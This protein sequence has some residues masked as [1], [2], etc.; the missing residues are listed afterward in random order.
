MDI[1]VADRLR[2]G[3]LAGLSALALT[4]GVTWWRGHAPTTGPSVPRASQDAVPGGA[5]SGL[6]ADADA[7]GSGLRRGLFRRTVVLDAATG[8]VIAQSGTVRPFLVDPATGQAVSGQGGAVAG[9]G[10]PRGG[11]GQSGRTVWQAQLKVSP[12]LPPQRRVVATR[13][14]PHLLQYRCVGPGGHLVLK[15]GSG[16]SESRRV[17]CDGALAALWVN[18]ADG[19]VR[20]DLDARGRAPVVVEAQLAALFP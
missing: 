13:G 18:P 17:R 11:A 8:R 6:A 15:V 1:D 4:A 12:G 2:A 19:R 16:R 9:D 7:P 3:V 14:G 20:V 10:G 5:A